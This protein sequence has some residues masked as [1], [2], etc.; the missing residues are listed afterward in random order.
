MIKQDIRYEIYYYLY[1]V[2]EHKK[3]NIYYY[4]ILI[5][6]LKLNIKTEVF[7]LIILIENVF[8]MKK[9][10]TKCI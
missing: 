4:L 3:V 5:S 9:N 6:I 7:L 2:C 1:Y 8:L 10:I